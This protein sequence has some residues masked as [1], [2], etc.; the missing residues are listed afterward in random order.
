MYKPFLLCLVMVGLFS[1][2][3]GEKADEP[4]V[5]KRVP[6]KK[7]PADPQA[8]T[9]DTSNVPP[10]APGTPTALPTPAVT[11]IMSAEDTAAELEALK[12]KVSSFQAEMQRRPASLDELMKKGFLSRI[13]PGPEGKKFWYDP[14]KNDVLLVARK[15]GELDAEPPTP[16]E[17]Q[18][19]AIQTAKEIRM[20]QRREAAGVAVQTVKDEGDKTLAALNSTLSSFEAELQRRPTSIA[21]LIKTGFLRE[22]PPSADGKKF[23]FDAKK[24]QI[25]AVDRKPDEK[26]PEPLTPEEYQAA[27]IKTAK[28][29]H[30]V[31][32][33]MAAGIQ[34]VSSP[35]SGQPVKEVLDENG[36]ALAALNSRLSSFEAEMRR[37]PVS[38]AELITTGFLRE[39][40]PSPP[41]KKF[42]FDPK[43][44]QIVVENRKPDEK[45][46]EPLT[47]EEFRIAAIKTA[48]EIHLAERRAALGG[49]PVEPGQRPKEELDE[50]AKALAALN[51]T[52]SS[53]EAEMQRHPTDIAELIKTGFLRQLPPSPEGKKYTYDAAKNQIAITERKPDEKDPQPLSAAEYRE[54]A[55]KTANEIQRRSNTGSKK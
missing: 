5:P 48:K 36:Q 53:F 13:P 2:G 6:K 23:A 50:N 45:D 51:S 37:N 43:K 19:A 42:S 1:G 21:D 32:K 41:G 9:T 55:I 10:P 7:A 38:I 47:A 16:Q 35:G 52:L 15:P 33:R 8:A 25:V 18:E 54:A 39:L 30:N 27:A 22:L 49:Q 17:L 34:T 28:E 46:P 20:N 3:C 11:E 4:V 31:E 12:V 29:I 26:D 40:P 14:V 44:N 24:N